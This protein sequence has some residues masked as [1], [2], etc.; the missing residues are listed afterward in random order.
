MGVRCS[1]N[2]KIAPNNIQI[3]PVAL[4]GDTIVKGRCLTAKN[5]KIHELVTITDLRKKYP[6]CSSGAGG[7]NKMLLFNK[8]GKYAD[9]NN[10]GRKTVAEVSV[11]KKSTGITALLLSAS[12]LKT[13]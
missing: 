4:I 6:C 3:G 9:I 12:F 10:K 5:I 11:E 2:T 8:S 13:S 1:E 7:I